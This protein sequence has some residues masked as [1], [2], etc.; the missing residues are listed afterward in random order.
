V[1]A[2]IAGATNAITLAGGALTVAFPL[3]IGFGGNAGESLPADVQNPMWLTTWSITSSATSPSVLSRLVADG[4]PSRHL[5]IGT[6]TADLA[7]AAVRAELET[8]STL[9][10]GWD[11]PQSEAPSKGSIELAKDL[12]ERLPRTWPVPKPMLSPGGEVGF[13]WNL[14]RRF[15]DI[16]LEKG[17]SLSIFVRAKDT[18]DEEFVEGLPAAE[19][20]SERLQAMLSRLNTTEA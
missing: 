11:G 3:S 12:L 20:S 16:V 15:A 2:N 19:V 13:Y 9:L 17:G 14:H 7:L 18:G 6:A 1:G 4:V 5:L 10:D 8:Y